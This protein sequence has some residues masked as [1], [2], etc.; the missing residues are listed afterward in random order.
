MVVINTQARDIEIRHVMDIKS[1]AYII[2]TAYQRSTH[3]TKCYLLNCQRGEIYSRDN[4][5]W[6]RIAD[7]FDYFEIHRII[8]EALSDERIPKFSTDSN[9]LNSILN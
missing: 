7:P 8:Q 4:N 1:S 2:V 5:H 6:N 3:R 9:G